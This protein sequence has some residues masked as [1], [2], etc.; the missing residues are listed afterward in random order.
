MNRLN[1]TIFVTTKCNLKCCYCYEKNYI[2]VDMTLDTALE[3]VCF[4]H[5]KIVEKNVNE[6]Y[7]QFHGG[8]PVLNFEIIKFIMD[9][10]EKKDNITFFYAMT[11]NVTLLEESMLPTILKIHNLSVSIDGNESVHDFN[12]VFKNGKGTYDIVEGNIRL[13]LQHKPELTARMTIT[14]DTYKQVILSFQHIISLGVRNIE[15]ELDFTRDDWTEEMLIEYEKEMKKIADFIREKK[16]QGIVIKMPI[17]EVA[18]N[19][20]TNTVCSGGKTSFTI[21]PDGK[22]YPCIVSLFRDEFFLGKIG[23]TLNEN[24]VNNIETIAQG[25]NRVC[26]GCARY[27]YCNMTRCKIINYIYTGDYHVPSPIMCVN[28]HL[29][30]KLGK[31]Y[32]EMT[33]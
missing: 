26:F 31:Y 9:E 4:I 18:A 30:V 29:K 2:P 15:I 23:E 32:K 33:I 14:P 27:E 24:I 12:R 28:E 25:E 8:E 22:V 13:L 21:A 20:T 16:E 17:F 1:F 11:T 7:V 6:G 3:V 5:E 10:L 19:R